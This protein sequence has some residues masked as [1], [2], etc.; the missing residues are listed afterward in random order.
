MNYILNNKKHKC[1]NSCEFI[2]KNTEKFIK[3]DANINI[4]EIG[5]KAYSIWID[6]LKYKNSEKH[7][8]NLKTTAKRLDV[9]EGVVSKAFNKL[10]SVGLMDRIEK[11]DEK[12]QKRGYHYVV[13]NT[14][15]SNFTESELS[16]FGCYTESQSLDKECALTDF[17]SLKNKNNVSYKE[18]ELIDLFKSFRLQKR[19][20]PKT[21]NL[22]KSY[23][24]KFDLE[25]FDKIFK[26]ASNAENIYAYIKK[27]LESLDKKNIKTLE[28]YEKDHQKHIDETIKK[29]EKTFNMSNNENKAHSNKN[30][31]SSNRNDY[32]SKTKPV[33]TRYHNLKASY[34]NYNEKELENLLK[35]SQKTKFPQTTI[36]KTFEELKELYERNLGL[37][38]E[39]A[40][41]TS[42]WHKLTTKMKEDVINLLNKLGRNIP[43]HCVV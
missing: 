33:I 39:I 7:Y 38:K 22:I 40:I 23:K 27:V 13:Y 36:E 20:M 17:N 5:L 30:L 12:G 34:L 26:N 11:R 2:T 18:K 19:I 37:F 41:D 4:K 31:S 43:P 21:I 6:T 14:Y 9:S 16:S 3:I 1:Q 24:D 10:I 25:V 32:K 42:N 35:E 28:D 29:R 15:K 8:I